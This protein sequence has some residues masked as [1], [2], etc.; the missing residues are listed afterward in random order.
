[1]LRLVPATEDDCRLRATEPFARPDLQR[2]VVLAVEHDEVQD[3]APEPR[4]H[5]RLAATEHELTDTTCHHKH[6]L[7]L[8][9]PGAATRDAHVLRAAKIGPAN[10]P[11]QAS[12]VEVISARSPSGA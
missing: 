6:P 1:L 3:L 9:A 2:S 12:T 10:V 7:A 8:G 5:L 11:E 4:Q